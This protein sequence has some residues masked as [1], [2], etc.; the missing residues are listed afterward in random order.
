MKREP[1]VFARVSLMRLA[2]V[3]CFLAG[4][5]LLVFPIGSRSRSAVETAAAASGVSPVS[6]QDS[7]RPRGGAARAGYCNIET[8]RVG[9]RVYAHN[10]E[11]GGYERDAWEEPDWS[12]WRQLELE[13]EQ[14]GGGVL[15]ITMLRPMEWLE[16]AEASPGSEI[17]LDLAEMGA[18]GLA[19]VVTVS[20][21]P[22][23]QPG[24][25]QVVTATFSHPPSTQVLNVTIGPDSAGD[26]N[27]VSRTPTPDESETIGVTDN[28]LFWSV[29]QDAFL[30]IGK[31]ALGERVLTYHGDTK[32]ILAKLPRPGPEVV[33]NL[34]VYGEHV[35]FVGGLGLLAHNAYEIPAGTRLPSA[36]Y[37]KWLGD[38]G[39]SEFLLNN[40]TA[41][42]LG[43]ANGTTIGFK[44]A[45]V[46][47]SQFSQGNFRVKG[48][49]GDHDVDM[50]LIHEHIARR[51]GWLKADG[52]GNAA[53]ARKWLSE[54]NL[55]P[56]HAGG[57]SVQLIDSDL[58]DTIRHTGGAFD[59]RN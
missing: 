49:T 12:E 38:R 17:E 30:P 45:R 3:A 9:E 14:P 13:M 25:G 56:H 22:K 36:T 44:R 27:A 54:N 24:P 19:R 53:K 43:L 2:Y 48:M 59:L 41:K 11:I 5:T 15:R 1:R 35:Y 29:D 33:Y 8:I 6:L 52:S 32:R 20:A 26:G 4:A 51:K 23:V 58:H 28:H 47:F 37:G 39:N 7:S 34:E 46:D 50:S 42:Q 40:S 21:G 57:S 10:P 31:M 18:C 16:L 55:T